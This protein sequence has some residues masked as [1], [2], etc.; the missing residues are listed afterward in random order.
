[1]DISSTSPAGYS[2]DKMLILQQIICNGT[3]CMN[4]MVYHLNRTVPTEEANNVFEHVAFTWVS[5]VICLF[6]LV[7]NAISF[8][9]LR[10][11]KTKRNTTVMLLRA[12][13]VGD[14]MDLLARLYEAAILLSPLKTRTISWEVCNFLVYFSQALA[15]WLVV[16]V[17]VE[18]YISVCHP[19]VY[20]PH[21]CTLNKTRWTLGIT[22]SL[23][24]MF[25]F[26]HF[27]KLF[28]MIMYYVQPE[29]RQHWEKEHSYL[30]E[31]IGTTGEWG[32]VH[33][34]VAKAL[35][36]SIMIVLNIK[37]IYCL[38]LVRR[39]HVM[40]TKES[41]QERRTTKILLAIVLVLL[42]GNAPA[43]IVTT[44]DYITQESYWDKLY[45]VLLIPLI[46]NSASN[47]LIYCMFGRNF[48][49]T[50]KDMMQCQSQKYRTVKKT[51]TS[52]V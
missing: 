18:R 52:A 15:M 41:R 7:G 16:L 21:W 17:T 34:I 1:M 46:I 9:A 19:L 5:M 49:T 39:R 3:G 36:I 44:Y 20:F 38:E 25:N 10:L 40:M 28:Y 32:L 11:D 6:G 43:G 26:I 35:P 14:S 8:F 24:L 23:C 37:L 29:S 27:I 30:S 2:T 47:F 12:L 31:F 13:A 48:R 51:C 4:S 22:V 45:A 33:S 50:V 42:L